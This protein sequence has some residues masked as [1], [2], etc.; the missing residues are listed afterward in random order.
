M[1]TLWKSHRDRGRMTQLGDKGSKHICRFP[2]AKPHGLCHGASLLLTKYTGWIPETLPAHP[3]TQPLPT[4]PLT[5][6]GFCK[7]RQFGSHTGFLNCRTGLPKNQTLKNPEV[8]ISH[9]SQKGRNGY[10]PGLLKS[11]CREQICENINMHTYIIIKITVILYILKEG[12][13]PIS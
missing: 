1:K 6:D 12:K 4:T 7:E 5:K 13:V 11:K 2:Q 3:Q 9:L 8:H 10:Q